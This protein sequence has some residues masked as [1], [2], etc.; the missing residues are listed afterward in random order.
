MS[1]FARPDFMDLDMRSTSRDEC[2]KEKR[3]GVEH[4]ALVI[5][6]EEEHPLRIDLIL[7]DADDLEARRQDSL[8]ATSAG[9][10]EAIR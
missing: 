3:H 4:P 6:S 10:R 8:R 1:R 9:R 7:V 5:R 2:D